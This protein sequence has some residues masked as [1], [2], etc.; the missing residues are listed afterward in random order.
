ME[1][2][3]DM[4]AQAEERATL[5]IRRSSQSQAPCLRRRERSGR[6]TR[7][8]RA[9]RR[10]GLPM[11][12]VDCGYVWNIS[13]QNARH[14]VEAE[15]EDGAPT[16]RRAR[17]GSPVLCGWNSRDGW[18]FDSLLHNTGSDERNL[19]VLNLELVTRRIPS[20]DREVR[21][22]GSNGLPHQ[23][24]IQTTMAE[25]RASSSKNRPRKANR[26]RTEWPT[27]R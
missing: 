6:P 22:R 1:R 12:G 21:R 13:A 2:V 26:W 17:L 19:E 4:A 14:S 8:E 16:E 20:P 24:T 25:D 15:D 7:V 23:S 18:I 11:V 3:H 10:K 5:V 9:R 27:T